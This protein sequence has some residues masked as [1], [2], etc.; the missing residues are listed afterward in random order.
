MNIKGLGTSMFM[1]CSLMGV[2]ASA[3]QLAD[4]GTFAIG[5]DRMFGYV[6]DVQ[7]YDQSIT[8]TTPATS[9]HYERTVNNFSLLGRIIGAEVLQ[10][11][12][13]SIDAFLGPGITV[14]GSIMY[15]HYSTGSSTNGQDSQS[16]TSTGAWLF[17]PRIGFAHMFTPNFGL[18][19][20]AG[21]MYVHV[22]SDNDTTNPTTGAVTTTNTTSGSLYFDL[23]VNLI[24][25]PVPH[26]A[27]TLGPTYDLLLSTSQS[28]TPAQTTTESNQHEH[29]LGVQ[30]GIFAWF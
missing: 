20:R 23:D 13:L 10:V 11:P 7:S 1:V 14:G 21:V 28:Y 3:Q 12:R 2:S 8:T 26:F 6:S 4:N 27:F 25:A 17:S 29:A 18:W 9:Y 22:S 16:K 19:P 24:L 5:V 15:D 30:A